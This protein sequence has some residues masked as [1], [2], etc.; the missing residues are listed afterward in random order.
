MELIY[1]VFGVSAGIVLSALLLDYV[2][3]YL[4]KRAAIQATREQAI[5]TLTAACRMKN[6]MTE[7]YHP[8]GTHRRVKVS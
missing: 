3:E 5:K 4:Q 2:I 1:T 7:K 6:G 8:H